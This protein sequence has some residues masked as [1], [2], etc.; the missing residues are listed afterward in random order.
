MSWT[1]GKKLTV[2]NWT[3]VSGSSG[4]AG[5]IFVGTDATGLTAAQLGQITFSGFLPGAAILSTG[6]IVP[7]ISY[8][9]QGTTS[10]DWNTTTNWSSNLAP[11]ATNYVV[12]PSG[13]PHPPVISSGAA[14]AGNLVLNAGADLTISQGATLTVNDSLNG[15]ATGKAVVSGAGIMVLGGI[16]AQSINGNLGDWGT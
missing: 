4:T 6:E 11:S 1:A 2:Y 13:T 16:N 10:T 5:R 15:G 8:V 3:G 12:I 7:A 14:T 9:W